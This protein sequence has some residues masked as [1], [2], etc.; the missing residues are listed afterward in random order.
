M[1][2]D[3]TIGRRSVKTIGARLTLWG[4][5]VTFGI[6]TTLC[7]AL[8][9]SVFFT[10]RA[11]VD[12]FLEGEVYELL[13]AVNENKGNDTALEEGF[14]NE[15]GARTL[16]DLA[17]RMFDDQGRLLITSEK[18]DVIAANWKPGPFEA[19]PHPTPTFE[20]FTP[21]G[22]KRTFRLCTLRTPLKDGRVCIAQ[23]SYSLE[24]MLQSLARFRRIC[25]VALILSV[26]IS[27]A[28]GRFLAMRSLKP[29]RLLT[30]R[31]RD[32]RAHELAQRLPLSGSGDELDA[33]VT[34]LNELLARI[35]RHVLQLRQFTADASHEL[36]TPLAALRGATEVAL[37]RERSPEGL[38]HVLE[39][40]M[41]HFDRLQKVAENLLLLSRLDAGEEVLRKEPFDLREAIRAMVELYRPVAEEAGV[42]LHADALPPLSILG[43]SGRIR[44]V[45]SNLLDNA[46]KYTS[47]GGNVFVSLS[48]E[49]DRAI[50]SIVDDGIGIANDD[51]AH[52]FDR[53]FCAD[54]ARSSH[55]GRGSGLGL[56]ICRSIVRAHNGTIDIRSEFGAGTTVV[57]SLPV[58]EPQ[59][60]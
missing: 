21:P 1:Y 40:N 43:D 2:S 11:E 24:G 15:L 58:N 3:K 20:S 44:Q 30:A 51:L 50:V 46:V 14:R 4:A 45:L 19:N 32:I 49:Q 36:R 10:L 31:A 52:V 25:L 33:L 59:T 13:G 38:R 27:V 37:S 22:T 42:A 53:F 9:A 56:S 29:L 55:N 35:E 16:R 26:I 18:R 12:T 8:Y 17:F 47:E 54:R 5:L 7:V 57:V 34:T 39:D 60:P 48:P 6:C 41:C 28:F 23:A